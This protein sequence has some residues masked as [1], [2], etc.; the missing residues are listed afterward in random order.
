METQELFTKAV[1]MQKANFEKSYAYLV[2]FQ[3]QVEKK[4]D[5]FIDGTALI[6]EPVKQFYKQWAETTRNGRA[7]LKKYTDEGYEGMK[8]YFSTTH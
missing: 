6:P 2:N 3:E 5:T 7:A 4:V 1:G 8:N